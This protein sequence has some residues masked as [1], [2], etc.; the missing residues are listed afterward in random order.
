[1]PRILDPSDILE[2]LSLSYGA[3]SGMQELLA[4]DILI[5]RDRDAMKT[6]VDLEKAKIEISKRII[7]K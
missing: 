4:M 1:M 7:G 3:L 6:F 5:R 2:D